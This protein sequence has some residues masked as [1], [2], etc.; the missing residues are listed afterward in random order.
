MSTH[1][2]HRVCV[3]DVNMRPTFDDT[4]DAARSQISFTLGIK[5]SIINQGTVTYRKSGVHLSFEA[6]VDSRVSNGW[7]C[8]ALWTVVNRLDGLTFR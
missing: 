3:L 2:L 4:T 8:V 5:S 6:T 1:L 7:F